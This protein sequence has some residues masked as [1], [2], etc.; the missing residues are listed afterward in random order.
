VF[1][2]LEIASH[3]VTTAIFRKTAICE[4]KFLDQNSWLYTTSQQ[5]G[6]V[7]NPIAKLFHLIINRSSCEPERDRYQQ[8]S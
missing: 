1:L 7:S 4:N 6:S 3:N 8:I 2:V 5:Q